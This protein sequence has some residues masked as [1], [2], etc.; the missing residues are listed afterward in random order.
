MHSYR[1]HHLFGQ[2]VRLLGLNHKTNVHRQRSHVPS[3]DRNDAFGRRTT[4]TNVQCALENVTLCRIRDGQFL[5]ND[6]G[7]TRDHISNDPGTLRDVGN[8]LESFI[9]V[10]LVTEEP[11]SQGALGFGERGVHRWR[12]S[13]VHVGR[14][15]RG[16]LKV[17]N[18]VT[19]GEAKV[20]QKSRFG[21]Q[22]ATENELA[23]VERT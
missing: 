12:R 3:T 9:L 10:V 4:A 7:S 5:A 6:S 1:S 22:Q 16:K 2:L 14:Q 19:P 21:V 18:Q 17:E 20:D 23:S 15:L 13:V 8:E 11:L